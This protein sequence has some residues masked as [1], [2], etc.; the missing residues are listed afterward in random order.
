[1]TQDF[2][3]SFVITVLAAW[4]VTHLM[5]SEDG[6]GDFIVRFRA[7]LGQGLAGELMD[8]FNCLSLWVAVPAAFFVSRRPLGWRFPGWPC[9]QRP[10][11]WNGWARNPS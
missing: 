6:P 1:M 8:C 10:A 9:P 5:S 3:M 7:R 4:R 11:Y 2:W